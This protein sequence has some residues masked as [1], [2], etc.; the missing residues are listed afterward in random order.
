[1]ENPTD[2]NSNAAKDSIYIALV[3]SLINNKIKTANLCWNE[4]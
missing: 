4:H 1:V 3:T 2:G